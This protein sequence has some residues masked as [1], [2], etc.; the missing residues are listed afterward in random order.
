MKSEEKMS[1]LT[2]YGHAAFKIESGNAAVA[3]DPYFA[4]GSGFSYRDM[5]HV[6]V[7]LITHDHGDH[8]GEA[9]ELCR[10]TG[11][12]LGCIVGTAEAMEKRGMPAGQ[13][14][15]GIGYSIGGTL[16][17]AGIAATMVQAFHSSDTGAPTGFIVRMPDGATFYHAG[18]TGIFSSMSLF[19]S[20]YKINMALLPIGG[21]FTMDAYQA[22]HACKLLNCPAVVPMHWGTFPVLAKSPAQFRSLLE[23]ICPQCA[24]ME[25]EPGKSLTVN[26]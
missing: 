10:H 17:Y 25:L 22:A 1:V 13:I 15:N 5:G 24:C 21:V 11:A 20:L 4:P 14:W 26:P 16:E 18:D 6:D 9:V 23:Q 8:V 3:I 19:G 7:V 12:M 2:W